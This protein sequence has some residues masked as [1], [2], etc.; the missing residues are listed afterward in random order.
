MLDIIF[1]ITYLFENFFR[2][3]GAVRLEST[4]SSFNLEILNYFNS[5]QTVYGFG[6]LVA[7]IIFCRKELRE[8]RELPSSLLKFV[9]SPSTNPEMLK[10]I[11]RFCI[12]VMPCAAVY[13]LF[14]IT[15][16]S[17]INLL[18]NRG[19]WLWI[20]SLISVFVV[21]IILIICDGRKSA[22]KTQFDSKDDH[23]IGLTQLLGFIPGIGRFEAFFG[24]M[25]YLGYSCHQAFRYYVLISIPLLFEIILLNTPGIAYPL[26]LFF[27]EELDISI[28]LTAFVFI[29]V[30]EFLSLKFCDWFWKR[31]SLTAWSV[32]CIISGLFSLSHLAIVRVGEHSFFIW[33]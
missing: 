14:S 8:L 33:R 1:G 16:K 22:H 21:P 20:P 32:F 13:L 3:I 18:P 30:I 31:V 27:W 15:H 25:R 24:T 9:R 19:F 5:H 28:C 6:S 12:L 10:K 26:P 23:K 11:K 4:L 7:M 29:A 17:L 2:Y